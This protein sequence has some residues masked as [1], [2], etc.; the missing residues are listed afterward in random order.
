MTE[1]FIGYATTCRFHWCYRMFLFTPLYL[2]NLPIHSIVVE[3]LQ[4]TKIVITLIRTKAFDAN[5]LY[6][7]YFKIRKL[8]YRR[9]YTELIKG[10]VPFIN[11]NNIQL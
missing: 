11:E 4:T 8:R 2:N 10:N 1:V 5:D 3:C 7:M 6:K 9:R